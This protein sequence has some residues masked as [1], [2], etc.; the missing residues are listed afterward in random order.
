MSIIIL[1][2]YKNYKNNILAFY[3]TTVKEKREIKQI[4]KIY[5]CMHVCKWKE[6]EKYLFITLL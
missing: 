5:Y 3:I 1:I 2:I 6:K 4:I